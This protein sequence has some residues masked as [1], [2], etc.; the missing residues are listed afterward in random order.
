MTARLLTPLAFVLWLATSLLPGMATPAQAAGVNCTKAT[1]SHGRHCRAVRKPH[2]K[3][4]IRPTKAKKK[5]RRA[6]SRTDAAASQP[7]KRR[8]NATQANASGRGKRGPPPRLVNA[9]PQLLASC[10][11]TQASRQLLRSR[12]VYVVDERTGTVLTEKQANRILPIASI[13]KLMTSVVALDSGAPLGRKLKVSAQDRDYEKFTGS[14]LKVGSVLSRKDMLH[15]ALM[16]SENRAAAALSRDYRGGRP[17]FV[18]AMNRK[19]RTLGMVN[20]HF[21]NGTG[22]SPRNVS[23]ARDL[24]KLVAA[25]SRYPRIGAFSVDKKQTMAPGHGRLVY[26]NS[27]PLV[28]AGDARITLQKT[29]FINEAGHCVVMRYMAHGR[30]V[31]IVLLGAP[32][33]RAHIADAVRIRQW[34]DCSLR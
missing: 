28:R 20:T 6:H 17:A 32:E 31:D 5:P 12:A 21:V 34:L 25:A 9:R 10:G 19:A 24:A 14:R 13:S 4:A 15:I 16:S 8:A 2:V 11:Y 7:A 22:L 29:G 3:K 30:P 18:A 33:P 23:T 27:N 26:V 1:P